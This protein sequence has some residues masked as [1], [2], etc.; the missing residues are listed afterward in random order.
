MTLVNVAWAAK[1][2]RS[3]GPFLVVLYGSIAIVA[4][5][6][7]WNIPLVAYAGAA[8]LIAGAVWNIALKRAV[9]PNCPC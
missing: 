4:A 6:L 3:T 5:R 8:C 2:H 9:A 7:V 1:R